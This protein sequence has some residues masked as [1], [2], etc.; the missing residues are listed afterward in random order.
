MYNANKP[1][2]EDL[3]SSAQLIRS[4]ILAAIAI[5]VILITVVMPAEYGIDPTRIGRVI[6]LTEMGEIKT[7]LAQEAEED[8]LRDLQNQSP[9]ATDDKSSSWFDRL[10]GLFISTAHAHGS[11]GH[12]PGTAVQEHVVVKLEPGQGVEI[13]LVM[14]KG[15]VADFTWFAEGGKVNFD[16]HGDG[17]GQQIS[18]EQ[19]RGVESQD[20][21][22]MAAFTGNHGWFWRNRDSQPVTITLI[23]KGEF[24]EVKRFD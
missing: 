15:A 14:E 3:P 24:S 16:L 18:Y 23:V 5:V 8:R 12:G 21:Q 13:K 9:A 6:G 7:Q 22:F 17:S 11:G 1:K 20:G 4:T 19:G 10:P 2:P